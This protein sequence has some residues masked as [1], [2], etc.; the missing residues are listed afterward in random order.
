[1]Q[2]RAS[3]SLGTILAEASLRVYEQGPI[4]LPWTAYQLSMNYN[5]LSMNY[6]QL[7]TNVN[8]V[9][10]VNGKALLL[11]CPF[12]APPP[13][14]TTVKW[15]VGDNELSLGQESDNFQ[16]FNN[17]SLL[18]QVTLYFNILIFVYSTDFKFLFMAI[19]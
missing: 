6:N 15:M 18:I 19:Q 1:M 9:S 3:N 11:H 17:G 4:L 12:E 14:V 16:I 13:P 10:T 7:A 5:Q 2:C 8:T